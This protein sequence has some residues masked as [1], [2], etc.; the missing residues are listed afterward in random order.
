MTDSNISKYKATNCTYL[1][2]LVLHARSNNNNWSNFFGY[3]KFS[4][5]V[6]N[7][8]AI[9]LNFQNSYGHTVLHLTAIYSSIIPSSYIEKLLQTGIDPNITDVDG[10]TAL[11]YI[12][13]GNEFINCNNYICN[14]ELVRILISASANT[15]I[16]NKDGKSAIHMTNN[17]EIIK[18]L[19]KGGANVDS[20]IDISGSLLHHNIHNID[21]VKLLLNAGANVN[22]KNWY[23]FTALH[24]VNNTDILKLLINADANVN[25]IDTLGNTIL[26][27]ISNINMDALEILTNSNIYINA[28]NNYGFTP[29]HMALLYSGSTTHI[30]MV[31]ALINNGADVK[32][33]NNE[34]YTALHIACAYA[35]DKN[36]KVVNEIYGLDVCELYHISKKYSTISDINTVK[37]LVDLNADIN[38]QST[39]GTTPLMLTLHN[40]DLVKLLCELNCDVNILDNTNESALYKLS[41][42]APSEYTNNIM[43][44]L[45]KNGADVMDVLEKNTNEYLSMIHSKNQYKIKK[46]NAPTYIN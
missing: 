38:A 24:Y 43:D 19:I 27:N 5:V 32:M 34:G 25:D 37:L 35:L 44:V 7:T 14:A 2:K 9:Y 20:I 40:I 3:D 26:H 33:V 41:M 12:I 23:G 13:A 17:I 10:N 30:S 6:D 31:N 11:H 28:K 29:L 39:N 1:M 22:L 46:A 36:N 18:L 4:D 42:L 21:M 8:N 15:N 45:V 16:K